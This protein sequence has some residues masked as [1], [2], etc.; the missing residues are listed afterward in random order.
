MLLTSNTYVISDLTTV[1]KQA[2][3]V[4]ADMKYSGMVIDNSLGSTPV[5]VTSGT[6]SSLTAIYP[7]SATEPKRGKVV[8]AGSIQTFMKD[9]GHKYIA[10]IRESGTADV[11]ISTG[12]GE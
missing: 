3:L 12:S 1:S 8:A 7:T 11:V 5:F 10:A 2:V 9:A 6:E 4:D